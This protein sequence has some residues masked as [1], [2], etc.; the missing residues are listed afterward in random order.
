VSAPTAHE[1]AVD[2]QA[3]AVSLGINTAI[4]V[5]CFIVFSFVRTAR[6]TRKFYAPK[7]Y[8]RCIACVSSSRCP[9]QPP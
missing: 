4:C 1:M 8:A 9:K 5:V 7:R 6:L 3:F 2:T